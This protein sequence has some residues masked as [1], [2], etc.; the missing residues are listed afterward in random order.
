[1]M[2][3]CLGEKGRKK[4]VNIMSSRSFVKKGLW[5]SKEVCIFG[6]LVAL[7]ETCERGGKEDIKDE[8]KRNMNK[9]DLIIF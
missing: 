4:N 1:M 7:R 5:E 2:K 8:K 3:C 9:E 6:R